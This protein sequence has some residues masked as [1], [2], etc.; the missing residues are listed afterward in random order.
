MHV[1][2]PSWVVAKPSRPAGWQG[3]VSW[4]LCP[5]PPAPPPLLPPL[6]RA[7]CRPPRGA[8]PATLEEGTHLAYTGGLHALITLSCPFYLGLSLSHPL[9]KFGISGQL[10]FLCSLCRGAD[11][12][13]GWSRW[14]GGVSPASAPPLLGGG[15][16]VA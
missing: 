7:L 4:S 8:P 11:A 12:L 13:T 14:G 9:F 3:G 10:S 1:L 6:E 2:N 15:S 16:R 5:P